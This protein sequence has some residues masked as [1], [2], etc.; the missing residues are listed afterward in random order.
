[1]GFKFWKKNPVKLRGSDGKFVASNGTQDGS[2]VATARG[3]QA[4]MQAVANTLTGAFNLT[5]T[6]QEQALKNLE[7]KARYNDMIEDVEGAIESDGEMNFEQMAMQIILQAMNK[8]QAPQDPFANTGD[9]SLNYAIP[10]GGQDLSQIPQAVGG[11]P[12][13]VP[14][15]GGVERLNQ[16]LKALNKIPD[17]VISE[18][19]IDAVCKHEGIEKKELKGVIKKLAPV[20]Q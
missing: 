3:V 14:Q 10:P 19:A 13:P 17:K 8:P 2:T 1:M 12:D 9:P 5:N 7:M 11:I 20:I 16:V 4:D 18:Q 6:I 15:T